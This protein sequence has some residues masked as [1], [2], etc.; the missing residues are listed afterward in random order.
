LEQQFVD[1]AKDVETGTFSLPN[2][3]DY[4]LDKPPTGPLNCNGKRV[5]NIG[6]LPGLSLDSFLETPNTAMNV[7]ST[8]NYVQLY[9]TLNTVYAGPLF[10]TISMK[11]KRLTNINDP[12]LIV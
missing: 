6:T 9:N 1:F 3:T 8:T 11:D 4:F 7:A 10:S 5:E 2:T 12:E